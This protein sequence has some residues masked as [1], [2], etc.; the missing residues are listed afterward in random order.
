MPLGVTFSYLISAPM[1]NEVAL[2]LLY[3]LFGWKIAF[4]YIA[5]GV[6]IAILS[7]LLIGKLKLE[8]HVEGYVWEMKM[9]NLV[10]LG[11]PT[12]RLRLLDS[13]SLPVKLSLKCGFM[14][15]S[16]LPL[17]DLCMVGSRLIL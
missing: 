8:K 6:V 2:G 1:V 16:E 4:I 15:L 7:G 9:G 10:D 13:W 3:V 14:W 17:A 11:K 12:Q 5:S